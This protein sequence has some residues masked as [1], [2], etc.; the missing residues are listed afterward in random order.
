MALVR[1]LLDGISFIPADAALGDEAGVLRPPEL[2]SLDSLHLATALSLGPHLAAFVT[3]DE[4]LAD[5]ARWY[6]LPV[7]TPS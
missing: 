7:T 2:R 5:A 4:R 6:G 3:Y 1:A